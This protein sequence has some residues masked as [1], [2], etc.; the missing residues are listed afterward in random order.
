MLKALKAGN[1][2]N[3]KARCNASLLLL[4]SLFIVVSAMPNMAAAQET[5]Q[6]EGWQFEVAPYMWAASIGATTASG[7]DIEI[8]FR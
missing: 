6:E 7:S 2:G 4:L 1:V 8:D 3:V 5:G